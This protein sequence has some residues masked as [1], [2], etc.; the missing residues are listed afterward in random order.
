[1][2]KRIKIVLEIVNEEDDE[3][4]CT[5]DYEKVEDYFIQSANDV[6][7][8][9]LQISKLKELGFHELALKLERLNLVSGALDWVREN[10]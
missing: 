3:N 10:L 5:A 9:P 1:M 7:Q 4:L 2:D 8:T 6:L